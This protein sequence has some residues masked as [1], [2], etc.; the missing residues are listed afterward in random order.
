MG[1]KKQYQKTCSVK[2]A[3]IKVK[4]LVLLFDYVAVTQALIQRKSRVNYYPCLGA[5][6]S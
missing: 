1:L 2:K 3:G 6:M 4:S 5:V